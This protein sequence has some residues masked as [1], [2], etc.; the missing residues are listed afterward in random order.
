MAQT[1]L[2]RGRAQPV[3]AQD[4]IRRLRV[5]GVA[6]AGVVATLLIG[7]VHLTQGTADVDASDLW[8]FVTG[9]G[10][11]QAAAVVIASRVPRLLAGLVVGMALG[12][13]GAALQSIARNPLASP[14]TL[15]INAGAYLAVVAAAAFGLTLPVLSS[16]AMA[17]AGG[18]LAAAL[19]LAL[20]SGAGAGPTRLVLA[21]SAISLALFSATMV[22][23]LLF[24]QNTIGLFA[25]G[26]GSLAQIGL[27]TV[28]QVGPVV[29]VCA[30]GLVLLARR[31]D[32]LG[33]G[34]DTAAVLGVPVRRTR[35][36]AVLLAVLLAAAAVTVAGPVGFVGL[37]APALV[38]LVAPLVPGL[39]RHQV[40]V[41]MAGLAGV[42]VV[43][44]ADV[45]VR[46]LLGAQGAIE[47][48][49]GVVTTIFGA[50]F[51]VVL[52]RRFRDSGPVRNAPAARSGRLRGPREFVVVAVTAA[53][54]T[55]GAAV[56]GLLLGDAVVLGGDVANWMAGRSGRVV[57]FVLDAR[58]PRV[59]AALLAGAA[60]AVAGA[61]VQAVC[62]NPLAEPGILGVTGGAG[63]GAVLVIT[64]VPAAGVWTLTGAAG[65]GALVA[66][67]LVF[68]LAGRGGLASDRLVLIG[69]GVSAASL[70][71]ITAIIVVSDPWNSTK[72]LTWLSGSTYGRTLPQVVPVAAA[73]LLAVP[74]LA[75]ARV[76]LD[77]MALDEDTPRVL[78][79][80]LE[81]TRLLLLAG[82]ALLTATAVSAVGVIAFVGLVA[83]HAARMLV[84]GRHVR[85][86]PVTALLGALLVCLADVLGRTVI[87][88][89]QLPAGLLTALIGTP[90]FVWLLW[91][92]R[93]SG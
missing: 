20:S 60:L 19:V 93:S 64:F 49:T 39:H 67:A 32:I 51:L 55:C 21:G 26:E 13:A 44:G 84:G 58:F 15:G 4:P 38:R 69:V 62:R 40:L 86:L 85:V 8:L 66:S 33:L 73:L 42:L 79:I 80:R 56:A 34:D 61:A 54:L 65:L 53:A 83:P 25:W 48:P 7:A 43:L 47:V 75:R 81:R 57:T 46:A 41:P 3:A 45:L 87:A 37:C 91:R 70:A 72:A 89:A 88:P 50:V 12:T 36:Y 22:L 17:F 18:L 2:A 52:A 77:V 9:G 78:G 10:T 35:L 6:A 16:G 14:D 23:L 24:Q 68:V 31:L 74:V 71:M 76:E 27:D 30:A 90:Y 59:L 92:S 29:L 1:Q 28:T 82:A 63:V 5:T 11:D